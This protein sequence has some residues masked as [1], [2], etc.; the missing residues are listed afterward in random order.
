[1]DHARGVEVLTNLAKH[2]AAL[3]IEGAHSEGVRIGVDVP[4]RESQF[5]SGPDAEKLVE[6][7]S[8]FSDRRSCSFDFPIV[9]R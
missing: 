7:E 3:A 5:F 1:L 4:A 2:V 8:Y 9:G 6:A